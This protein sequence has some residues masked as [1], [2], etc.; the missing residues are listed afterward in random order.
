MLVS[1]TKKARWKYRSFNPDEDVRLSAIDAIRQVA[2]SAGI[3]VPLQ[4][5][6]MQNSREHNIRAL[7]VAGIGVALEI[8]TLIIHNK[9][10][11]PPL[12][13][14][15]I[16]T[17]YSHPD[18]I[19]DAVQ[20][21]SLEVTDFLQRTQPSKGVFQTV[22]SMLSIGDPTAEN[23][24][25]TLS[26]YYIITNEY[27]KALRGEVNL[28]VGRK[29][30]GKTALFIQLRD[31]KRENKQN[32]IVDL[33]P[34]G[35]QLVKLKERLLDFLTVGAQQ[36]LITALWEYILLLEI[37]YKIL[38]KDREV[39]LRNHTLRD[40]YILLSTIYGDSKLSHEGDFRE[41]LLRLSDKLIQEFLRKYGSRRVE[42]AERLNF[43]TDQITQVLYHHDIGQLYKALVKYLALKGEIW[44]LFDNI[45][46]GWSVEGVGEED[47]LILRC[48]INASRKLEREFRS[49]RLFFRSIVFIR[50]DVYSLLMEGSSD[51]GKEMRAS[52]DWSNIELLGQLLKRRIVVSLES[53]GVTASGM[54]TE[55][56]VSHYSGEPWLEFMAG[57]S[58]MRPRNLLKLFRHAADYA[59]NMGHDRVEFEDI[60]QGLL[61]YARDLI[62][63][64]NRE[65]TDIFPKA[66]GLIREFSEENSEF[67]HDELVLL[68]QLA[69]L[70]EADAQSVINFWLY[71]GVLGVRKIG[72]EILYIHDVQYDIEMLHV[73]IRKWAKSAKYV[74]TPALWPALRTK[75][76]NQSMLL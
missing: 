44:L 71:Y 33:K 59:I 26:E 11:V 17:K 21:F 42:G 39:H 14:R 54:L 41:R 62:I 7:F 58:L 74:V 1:R 72:E 23:E 22:L 35:Y 9:E 45:D 4:T 40:P 73:R 57:R 2:Q 43:T 19:A 52:L 70:S 6:L 56:S 32:V 55:V 27:Q 47:V 30:C 20:A 65:L 67:T 15:D 8:P 69:G 61:T 36:H 49:K 38:E 64:V 10:Y 34:E 60:T 46:R 66:K 48:L 29:G 28:V 16:T 31:A 5:S 50:D 18:D 63:E 25:A 68:I 51:Y 53:S 24:M 76:E 3:I 37:T 75:D 13:V 12:D